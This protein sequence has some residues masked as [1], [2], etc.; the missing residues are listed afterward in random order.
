MPFP[1]KYKPDYWIWIPGYKYSP[2]DCIEDSSGE[3]EEDGKSH[4][5]NVDIPEDITVKQIS[6]TEIEVTGID[7]CKVGKFTA[8]IKF[9]RF[10]HHI[11]MNFNIFKSI[12]NF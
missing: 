12:L 4:L 9:I 10:K 3:Y 1:K 5:D 8:E 11:I 6:N 2:Q 7:K